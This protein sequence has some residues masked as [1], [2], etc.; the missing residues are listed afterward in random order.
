MM[1]ATRPTTSP[2]RRATKVLGL[3]VAVKGVLG[4]V[5]QFFDGNAQGRHPKWIVAIE[6]VGQFHELTQR[7]FVL[8]ATTSTPANERAP[9]GQFLVKPWGGHNQD[10]RYGNPRQ[11]VYRIVVSKINCSKNDER[12]VGEIGPE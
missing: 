11:H 9:F 6:T 4:A 2:L 10:C 5:E 1:A 3:G 12:S 8:T 7:L